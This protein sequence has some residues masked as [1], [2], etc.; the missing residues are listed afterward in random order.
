MD[1]LQK[2]ADLEKQAKTEKSHYYVAAT[3]AEARL[4]IK[5]L[6]EKCAALAEV[7]R[8]QSQEIRDW[9]RLAIRTG[10]L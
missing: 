1:I 3:C 9:E 6:R 5:W 4:K 2:L 10:D 8:L 7:N